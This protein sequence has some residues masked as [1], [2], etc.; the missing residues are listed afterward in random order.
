MQ[1]LFLLRGRKNLFKLLNR[2]ETLT[3][4]E[5]TV[6]FDRLAHLGVTP[7]A[8]GIKV[9]QRKAEWIHPH[10]ARGA[11]RIIGMERQILAQGKL[12]ELTF[13]DSVLVSSTLPRP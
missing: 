13:T 1:E 5:L 8:H 4:D 9:L 10:M 2:S 6:R 12:G 11:K 7:T 3:A